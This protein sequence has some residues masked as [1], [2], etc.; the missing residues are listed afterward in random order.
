M[1]FRPALKLVIDPWGG[2]YIPIYALRQAP[3]LCAKL[4]RQ[5]KVLKSLT[6][7]VKLLCAQ[8]LSI[9]KS[10]PARQVFVKIFK[11]VSGAKRNP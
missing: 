3:T 11:T 1:V 5:K 8:L 6:Q 7:C 9:M 4:L 2:F 10:T